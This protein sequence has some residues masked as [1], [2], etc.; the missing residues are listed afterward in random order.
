MSPLIYEAE[1][2]ISEVILCF[3]CLFGSIAGNEMREFVKL[4]KYV[5]IAPK[6]VHSPLNLD[7]KVQIKNSSI[8]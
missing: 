2:G 7:Y 3:Q 1:N 8:R 6:T 5:V 4:S